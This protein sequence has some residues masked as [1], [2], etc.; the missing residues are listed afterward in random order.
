M[1]RF[2]QLSETSDLELYAAG[3]AASVSEKSKGNLD[4]NAP[5]TYLRD[6]RVMGLYDGDTLV[7]GYTIRA[8]APMRLIGYVPRELR[9]TLPLPEGAALEDCSEIISV[10]RTDIVSS[11]FFSAV[12]WPRIIIDAIRAGKPYILG[13]AF[14]TKVDAMYKHASPLR[15]YA[16]PA[17]SGDID[18]TLYAYT[19][20]TILATFV[21]GF[22][23]RVFSRSKQRLEAA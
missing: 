6:A 19:P 2:R 22:T 8:C 13:L 7:G 17:S 1:I 18:V 23:D 11:S 10:W 14:H 20:K 3:F 21:V 15:L 5:T 4:G 12:V 16:G 9:S